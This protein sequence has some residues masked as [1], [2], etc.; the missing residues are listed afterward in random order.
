MKKSFLIISILL[1]IFLF[2]CGS[3]SYSGATKQASY[4]E[5]DGAVNLKSTKMV[6]TDEA[7]V[8]NAVF[9]TEASTLEV[10]Q[11]YEQGRKLIKNGNVSLGVESFNNIENIVLVYAQNYNGY[12]TNTFMSDSYYSATIK[13]PSQNFDLAMNNVGVIGKVKSRSQNASDVT[14]TYYDLESR[15]ESKKILKDKLENYLKQASSISEL[16]EIERELNNV[17][18]ELEAMQ[19]RMKRLSNQIDYSTINIDISLPTGVNENGFVW[20]D[21]KEK[22]RRL[23]RDV[24][25]FFAGFVVLICYIAIYGLPIIILLAF[26]FWLLFGK[27]GLLVK[28]YNLIKRK[29]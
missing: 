25:D 29:K 9:Q 10:E 12:V 19:G 21:L 4:R 6:M 5:V 11:S 16:M 13:V 17:I 3:K 18:S 14:D 24:V 28:L 26:L 27:I 22:F 1:S 7:V 8:E 15:I 20:P 2:S 23:G